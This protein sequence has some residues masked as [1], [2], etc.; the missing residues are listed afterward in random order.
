MLQFCLQVG[1]AMSLCGLDENA[2][3]YVR[4]LVA[5]LPFFFGMAFGV[6]SMCWDRSMWRSFDC[7]LPCWRI[8]S[9]AVAANVA[10]R[11]CA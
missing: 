5:I 8:V 6:Y 4:S 2:R 11:G 3:D 9:W 7:G 10:E 1:V